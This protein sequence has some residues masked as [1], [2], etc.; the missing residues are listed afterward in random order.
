MPTGTTQPVYETETGLARLLAACLPG[1]HLAGALLMGL[2]LR[3]LFILQYPT[4]TPD[5]RLYD[6]LARNWLYR[7]VY[8]LWLEGRLVPVGVRAPGYPAFLAAVYAMAGRNV[9]AVMLTQAVVDL[10]TCVLIAFLAALVTSAA[11]GASAAKASSGAG[12]AAVI[13]LWL[14]A[15]C[16]FTAN[17]TAVPLTEPLAIFLTTLVLLILVVAFQR[18][19]AWASRRQ[20]P[21]PPT[22]V[23]VAGKIHGT[24]GQ[25]PTL[26]HLPW[27]LAGLVAGVGTLV[28][29]E[30]PLLLAVAGLV[31]LARWWRPRNLGKL[32]RAGLLLTVGLAVPLA[33]WAARNWHTLGEVQFLAPRYAQLP[34]EQPPVG[35]YAW[36]RTWQTRYKETEVIVWKLESEPISID[37]VPASAFDSGQ[38]RRKV[39]ALLA[40]HNENLQITAEIDEGF[41]QLAGER[42]HRHPFRTWLWLPFRR[43]VTMWFTPRIE[44]LPYSGQVFPLAKEW[45]EDRDD[46]LWT[47]GL[48][49]VN[50]LYLALAAAGAWKFRR[51]PEVAFLVAFPLIRTVLFTQMDAPEPRY[52]LVC[53]PAII[54]LASLALIHKSVVAEPRP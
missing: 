19:V 36:A 35:F 46:L 25:V 38:E 6:E 31:L 9:P 54:A 16:P 53:F 50:L 11:T 14:A 28:R 37:D 2:A 39:A 8:G 4:E 23:S 41:R 30:T 48:G 22:A 13:A 40:Q 32:A 29:P 42:A 33:P 24:P 51:A 44:L 18:E 7:G 52:L 15:L 10:I 49:L 12:R 21:S 47:V 34:G 45:D 5:F 20:G 43:A 26:P 1:R 17:Y 3:L 27:F